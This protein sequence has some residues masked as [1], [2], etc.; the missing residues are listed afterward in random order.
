MSTHGVIIGG[1]TLW[2]CYEAFHT[3]EMISFSVIKIFS[4]SKPLS[5]LLPVIIIIIIIYYCY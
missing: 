4:V 2:E 1:K 5:V 3:L